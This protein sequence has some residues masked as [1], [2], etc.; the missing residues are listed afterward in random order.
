MEVDGSSYSSFHGVAM[1]R[2]GGVAPDG[3]RP[4]K[5]LDIS[6]SEKCI[7]VDP[8][9]GFAIWMMAKAKKKPSDLIGGPDP[10]PPPGYATVVS[11]QFGAVT[12]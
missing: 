2:V 10:D 9:D 7:L 11:F 5:N 1:F 8:G 12:K 6:G 3:G 4:E